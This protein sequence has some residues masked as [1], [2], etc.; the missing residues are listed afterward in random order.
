VPVFFVGP[1]IKKQ[2]VYR[3]VRPRD[4]AATVALKLGIAAPSGSSGIP[5]PEAFQ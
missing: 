1:G 3:L 4:I 5:I 2:E